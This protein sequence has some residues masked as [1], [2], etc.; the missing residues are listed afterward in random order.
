MV[1]HIN[2][3]IRGASARPGA[4][5]TFCSPINATI[6][7]SGPTG[8]DPPFDTMAMNIHVQEIV[9]KAS[10]ADVDCDR[11]ASRRWTEAPSNHAIRLFRP[12]PNRWSRHRRVH[13]LRY[14][15]IILVSLGHLP[16]RHDIDTDQ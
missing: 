8:L 4:F 14:V 2:T 10:H 11:N 6:P 5:S 13:H 7:Y 1:A 9:C 12:V 15:S 16:L 3:P